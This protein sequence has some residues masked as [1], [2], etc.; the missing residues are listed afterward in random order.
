MQ[1]INFLQFEWCKAHT[2]VQSLFQNSNKKANE[3]CHA[4]IALFQSVA[5]Y[6]TDLP[7]EHD[8][9]IEPISETDIRENIRLLI[10]TLTYKE[11][12]K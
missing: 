12:R 3:L 5:T 6:D 2:E 1:T 11:A 4:A 10:S 7:N 9:T 8:I